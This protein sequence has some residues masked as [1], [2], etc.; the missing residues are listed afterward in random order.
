VVKPSVR[1]TIITQKSKQ[2]S[3]GKGRICNLLNWSRSS[4]YYKSIIDD[5]SI[6]KKYEELVEKLPNRGFEE[7]YYRT[8]REGYTWGWNRMLRVYREQGLVKRPKKRKRIPEELRK[9]LQQPVTVNEVWSMDF[10]SDTLSDGRPFRVL[11]VIDDNNRECLLSVGSVSFP[12]Q[13]VTR[14]LAE[15][16]EYYGKPKYIRTDNGPEYTSKEYRQW[17][18]SNGITNIYSKPGR[19][20]ENGYVERFNRTFREDV[21]GAYLF[22]SISQFQI[23]ADNWS[24]DYNDNHPHG[25]LGKMSPREFGNRR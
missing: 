2:H 12:S 25:S 13:R 23:I 14:H 1:R 5:S 15:L 22:S 3:I 17:C 6:I 18:A 8:R 16:V 19:P 20:M 9:P 24:E 10:M 7:Y 21:L 11:N 4:F